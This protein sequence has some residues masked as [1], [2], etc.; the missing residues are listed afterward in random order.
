[1]TSLRWTTE[2]GQKVSLRGVLWELVY[3]RTVKTVC[4]SLPFVSAK[5]A[6]NLVERK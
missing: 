2:V 4:Q 6:A 3:H 1:M 5:T